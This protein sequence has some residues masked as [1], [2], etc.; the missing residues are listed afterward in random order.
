MWDKFGNPLFPQFNNFFLN[1]LAQSVAVGDTS[2]LPKTL[3]QQM[4]WPFIIS[5]DAQKVGQINIRQII[6]GVSYFLLIWFAVKTLYMKFKVTKAESLTVSERL[7]IAIVV[8]GFFI[9][10][11]LFS[12]YRY[13]VPMD[14]LA[15]LFVFI[16]CKALFPYL[17]AKRIA[18]VSIGIA[19]LVVLSGTRTWWHEPWGEKLLHA[20]VPA[21]ADP[22]RTTVLMIEGDPPWAW[23]AI[24]FPVKVAFVQ[25]QGNFPQGPG[26][27]EQVKQILISRNGPAFAQFSAARDDSAEKV[28]RIR[29]Q[30]QR[31]GL[32]KN[33][34]RCESLEWIIEKF[35]LKASV[36]PVH[37]QVGISCR[38]E[39]KTKGVKRDIELENLAERDRAREALKRYSLTIKDQSCVLYKAG[40]ASDVR[41]YHWCP[42]TPVDK[43]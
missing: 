26:Y 27:P 13:M 15:P 9:W 35:K 22:S 23:L 3:W 7:I 10:M 8:L 4:L 36:V 37:E 12:I 6:W 28:N 40:I 32:T 19:T 11:K 17:W 38:L 41:V 29:V 1:P 21:L 2:W 24:A 14:M 16:L 25:I 30:V 42:T 31:L 20:E 43:Q 39:V 33:I 5:V 18:A 34:S